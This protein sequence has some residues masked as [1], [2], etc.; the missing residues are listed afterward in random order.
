M[1]DILLLLL[2]LLL[3][4]FQVNQYMIFT[5]RTNFLGEDV[6]YVVSSQSPKIVCILRY[7]TIWYNRALTISP[8]NYSIGIFNHLKLCL[9]DAI[10]NFK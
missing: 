6:N 3:W 10:H 8:P 5:I 7:A 1:V 9:A 4:L 2:F